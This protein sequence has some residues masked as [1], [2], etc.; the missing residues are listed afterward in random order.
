M[1]AFAKQAL[2]QIWSFYDIDF[3]D[4]YEDVKFDPDEVKWFHFFVERADNFV[5]QHVSNLTCDTSPD[6]KTFLSLQKFVEEQHELSYEK[7]KNKFNDGSLNESF[8]FNRVPSFGFHTPTPALW[9]HM[10][11]PFTPREKRRASDLSKFYESYLPLVATEIVV[12]MPHFVFM[13]RLRAKFGDSPNLQCVFSVNEFIFRD[14]TLHLEFAREFIKLKK[15]TLNGDVGDFGFYWSHFLEMLQYWNWYKEYCKG[16]RVL[17]SFAEVIG[18]A[19]FAALSWAQPL[20][21]DDVFYRLKQQ[22]YRKSMQMGV[23]LNDESLKKR[24]TESLERLTVD[25]G[26]PV[27]NNFFEVASTSY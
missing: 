24:V 13:S 2:S 9:D 23:D 18:I 16:K 5:G 8:Y 19:I 20:C 1:D 3:S 17:V 22:A 10:T 4:V 12:L 15:S 7:I 14:E 6:E 11:V 27:R 21:R 25:A 26:T